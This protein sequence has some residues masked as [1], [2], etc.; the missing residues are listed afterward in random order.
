MGTT[1]APVNGAMGPRE[2]FSEARP[3]TGLRERKREMKVKIDG[4]LC[5]GCGICEDICPDLFEMLM[6]CARA[7]RKLVKREDK[8]YCR[9][10]VESCP[11]EAILVED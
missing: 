3:M 9:E 4:D 7:K 5:S 8:E 10:A 11:N 2:G 6:D 1:V